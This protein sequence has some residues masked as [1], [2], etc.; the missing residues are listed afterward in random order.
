[1]TQSLAL[2]DTQLCEPKDPTEVPEAVSDRR[3]PVDGVQSE[4]VRRRVHRALVRLP[5]REREVIVL[6]YWS[7]L[8]RSEVARY[9]DIPP[10]AVQTRTQTALARLADI[11]EGEQP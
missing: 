11:L 2:I 6:A 1:M 7:G 10:G 4:R 5:E 8:S 3:E 9:L